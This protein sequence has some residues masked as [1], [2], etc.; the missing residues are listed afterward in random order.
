MD[1]CG[2]WR[3]PDCG[4]YFSCV[5]SGFRDLRPNASSASVTGSM[6]WPLL[7]LALLSIVGG[8]V[9][10]PAG[11][12]GPHLWSAWLENEFGAAPHPPLA[13]VYTLQLVAS[14]LPLLGI[15][16]ARLLVRREQAGYYLPLTAFLR[17][18]WKFDAIYK[19]VLVGCYFKLAQFFKTIEALLIEGTLHK[20][21]SGCLIFASYCRTGLEQGVLNKGI[22][23]LI[24]G[25]RL[26]HMQLSATQNG[27]L[28]RY[29]LMIRVGAV[30]LLGYWLW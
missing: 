14:L 21:T 16:I 18:G 12:P 2:D 20:M 6:A 19:T 15:G 13:T 8:F 9:E 3:I 11:W 22:N 26:A 29:A 5:F 30:F 4:L 24:T 7:I 28:S 25:L 17:D 23:G 27:L 10:F 1:F